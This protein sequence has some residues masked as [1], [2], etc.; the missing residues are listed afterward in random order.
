MTRPQ[1]VTIR[2]FHAALCGTGSIWP[3]G[4]RSPSCSLPC[5]TAGHLHTESPAPEAIP[6][7]YVFRGSCATGSAGPPPPVPATLPRVP[8]AGSHRRVSRAA[9]PRQE[10]PLP[11]VRVPAT[12][13]DLSCSV[14]LWR[15]GRAAV[16]RLPAVLRVGTRLGMPRNSGGGNPAVALPR[17]HYS[18]LDVHGGAVVRHQ[19][20]PHLP[21][22]PG[23]AP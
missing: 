2:L 4:F 13:L 21:P 15:A 19:T 22:G 17:L 14:H 23:A 18:G 10:S 9:C 8:V 1:S 5:T 20:R 7:L 12:H 16:R 6:V 3:L 11:R